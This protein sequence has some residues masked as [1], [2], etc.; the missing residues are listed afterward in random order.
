MTLPISLTGVFAG[1][2][3]TFIPACGDFINA[4]LLGTSKQ[5]MI[6]NVVQS[7]FLA[8]TDYPSAAAISFVLMAAI[9]AAVL[10]Y[11]RAVGT[12][13]AQLLSDVTQESDP[14]FTNCGTPQGFAGGAFSSVV[15]LTG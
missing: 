7:K 1:T 11:A 12:E 4:Q 15:T 2:L 6:G 8:V 5:H 14:A 10:I 13:T 9:L 3:L